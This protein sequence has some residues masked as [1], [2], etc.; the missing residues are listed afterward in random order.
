MNRREAWIPA[1]TLLAIL[2]GLV[3]QLRDHALLGHQAW[4]VGLY[5]TGLPVVFRTLRGMMR[6]G[7]F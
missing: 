3:L 6:G 4:M 1:A 7:G 2:L 5:L